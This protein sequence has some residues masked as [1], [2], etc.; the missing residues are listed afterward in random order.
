MHSVS[1]ASAG[2]VGRRRRR[3][4]RAAPRRRRTGGTP[5]AATPAAA[6]RPRADRREAPSRRRRPGG[7][8][9][10]RRCA[11]RPASRC[12]RAQARTTVAMR[13]R[14]TAACS[15]RCA[16]DSVGELALQRLD[17][18]AHVAGPGAR[19]RARRA[20]RYV[21]GRRAA[22]A[23]RRAPADAGE[24]AGRAH[25]PAQRQP[26]GALAQRHGVVD[27]VAD[28]LGL[29]LRAQR[30]EVGAPSSRDIAHDR[31]PR[32]RLVGELEPDR[33]LGILRAAVVPRLVRGDQPQLAHLRLERVRALDRVD[34]LGQR[35]PSRPSG[36]ASR[37]RRSTAAPG[38]A[39][40]GWCRRR[41]ACPARRGR[42]RRPGPFGRASARWRLRRCASVTCAV[43][44]RSSGSDC[45]PRLPSRAIRPCST[46]TVARASCRARW[47]GVVAAWKNARQRRRACSW[48][49]RRG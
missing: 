22:L 7:P 31:Q 34:A 5:R 43:N 42:C 16:A 40:C 39:G 19:R 27:R 13:S 48:A 24:H 6:S 38:C 47:F 4:W 35:R 12:M 11:Q 9:R 15:K 33:A 3:R 1:S 45:T 17:E 41:A 25:D 36:C 21:L 10:A 28:G 30:S 29:P 44:A 18:R 49:L 14:T 26:V 32:E 23:R 46:S 20:R 8:R 2:C 37:W